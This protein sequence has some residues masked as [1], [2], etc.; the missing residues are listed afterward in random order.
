MRF[1]GPGRNQDYDQDQDQ[2]QGADFSAPRISQQPV[3]NSQHE[4]TGERGRIVV[5]G[6]QQGLV[7]PDGRAGV[8]ERGD[9]PKVRQAVV[10]AVDSR[11]SSLVGVDEYSGPMGGSRPLIEEGRPMWCEGDCDAV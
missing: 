4:E 9:R 2:H 3:I 8:V 10:C 6:Q 5:V 11:V 1:S 7:R